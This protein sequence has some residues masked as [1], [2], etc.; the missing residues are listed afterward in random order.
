MDKRRRMDME[1]RRTADLFAN[2]SHLCSVC[3]MFQ[4][5]FISFCRGKKYSVELGN[6]LATAERSCSF[7]LF[8]NI[9]NCDNCNFLI[10]RN[11][12]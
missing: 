10:C 4:W 6:V 7:L 5:L 2:V 9:D 3:F 12:L 11:G 8:D 1:Q